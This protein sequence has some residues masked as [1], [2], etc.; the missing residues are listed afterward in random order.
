MKPLGKA[1]K[2]A[3]YRGKSV[4][5]AIDDAVVTHRSTPHPV[6]GV[7]PAEM[8]FRHKYRTALPAPTVPADPMKKVVERNALTKK[9]NQNRENMSGRRREAD[10]VL[11]QE[12]MILNTVRSSKYDPLYS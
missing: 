1:V 11:G 7:T 8:M 12:V 5:K 4:K 9:N 3:K 6:T 10:F 2:I